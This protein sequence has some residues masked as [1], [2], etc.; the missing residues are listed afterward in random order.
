VDVIPLIVRL[1]F[2][3][4]ESKYRSAVQYELRDVSFDI[5][6]VAI[7]LRSGRILSVLVRAKWHVYRATQY[8]VRLFEELGS[9]FTDHK[10]RG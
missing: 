2:S 1:D 8:G 7:I 5:L 3:L 10:L 4:V 9:T 6:H